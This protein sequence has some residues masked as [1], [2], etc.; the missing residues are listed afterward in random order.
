M[1]HHTESDRSAVES[2]HDAETV[3]PTLVPDVTNQKRG[4]TKLVR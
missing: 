2:C 4:S 1:L 3:S